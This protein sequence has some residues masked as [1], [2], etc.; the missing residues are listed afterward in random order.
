MLPKL[1]LL[2]EHA[3]LVLPEG[4]VEKSLAVREGKIAA[5]LDSSEGIAAQCMMDVNGMYVLPGG[6]DDHVHFNDPG[7]TWRDDFPHASRAAACGGVTTVI[8]MPMQNEPTVAN[9]HILQKKAA[10]LTGR[11]YVDFALWGALIRTNRDKLGDLQEAGAAA[12]KCFMS[13]PSKDY[14]NLTLEEIEDRLDILKSFGGL[15]GFH[16]EDC[17]ML[18]EGESQKC[19]AGATAR[20]DYLDVHSV[21][22]E[23]KAVRDLLNIVR[24][25]GGRVHICHVS[26]PEVA[27][28]IRKAKKE[29]LAVTAETCMHY[30]LLTDEDFLKKGGVL[31]CS[32]PLRSSQAAEQL[33]D[34]VLD[35]TID[36]ICSDHS[37]CDLAEKKED[38]P[39]GIF[40]A[41]GGLSGVQTT[42]QTC[43]DYVVNRRHAS[44]ALVT[45]LF[46]E[47]PAKIFGLWRRKGA[48][49]PGFDADFVLLDPNREWE[50]READLLY[51]HPFSAFCGQKGR[52]LPVATY[53]R[54]KR[55][56][57]SD[58]FC[59]KPSGHFLA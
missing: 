27:E 13:E 1:D 5:I 33:F 54:G 21:A 48:L 19:A 55:I 49:L 59:E 15:A 45:R 58:G 50:I 56:Y 2:V 46:A 39:R 30:L 43:W 28:L 25:T 36:T 52:G 23:K 40:G 29:G 7:F 42:L 26:H 34:Y 16:C 12:F 4:V 20:Q 53:L 10:Y 17:A 44:P 38:G 8:D 47:R 57:G 41:W 51:K 6:I 22:A 9:G 18:K 35:G 11:S 31:K 14:T 3:R 32:P 37:P 24:R